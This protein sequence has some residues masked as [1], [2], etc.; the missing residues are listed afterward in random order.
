[1]ILRKSC[2]L[3]KRSQLIAAFADAPVA[4]TLNTS[5]AYSEIKQMM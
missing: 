4:V 2:I 3:R 5:G 1:V